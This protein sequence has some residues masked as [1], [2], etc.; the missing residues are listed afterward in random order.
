[1]LVVCHISKDLLPFIGSDV[2]KLGYVV[3]VPST[4][5]IMYKLNTIHTGMHGGEVGGTLDGI[6]PPPINSPQKFVYLLCMQYTPVCVCSY[7]N[8]M[9]HLKQ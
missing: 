4:Q 6:P 1:M 2:R 5:I 9:F 7:A 8:Y 3:M